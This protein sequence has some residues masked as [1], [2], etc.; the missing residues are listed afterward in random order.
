[1][2]FGPNEINGLAHLM[3]LDIKNNSSNNIKEYKMIYI[4]KDNKIGRITFIDFSNENLTDE[5]I[6]IKNITREKR[7]V[8]S[9][10]L[11]ALTIILN[12][13]A[14]DNIKSEFG[15]DGSILTF[16]VIMTLIFSFPLGTSYL[17]LKFDLSQNTMNNL[18]SYLL[19]FLVSMFI[20]IQI[21]DS[22]EEEKLRQSTISEIIVNQTQQ[23][24]K[25]DK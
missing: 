4:G 14:V 25:C 1:M 13:F 15:I 6:K 20:A 3:S 23:E 17:K 2:Q 12:V 10:V 8:F 22:A 19:A 11:F 16:M 24:I 18:T 7:K 9:L 21:S 5:E